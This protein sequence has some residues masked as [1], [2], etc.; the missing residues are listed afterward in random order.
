MPAFCLRKEVV[1]GFKQA[2]RSGELNPFKMADMESADRHAF[3]EKYVGKENAKE[4]NTLFESKLLLKNQKAGYISWAKKVGGITPEIRRDMLA[5]IEKLDRVLN[6]KE[7]EIF[8]KDLAESRLGIDIKPE[9]AKTISD[10]SNKMTELKSKADKEGLFASKSDRAS[11]GATKVAL[12]EY[13]ND[14]KLKSRSTSFRDAP[15][16]KLGEMI[17]DLPGVMKSSLSSLDNSFWGRQGIKTLLDIRTSHIWVKNFVKSFGDISKELVGKDAIAAIKA[18]IYSRPNALNGKY[19]AGKYGLSV[20]SEE[21][22]PSSLPEKIPLLGKLF[23]ASEAAYNGAALRL[24]ADLADRLIKKAEEQGINTLDPKQAE[25]MGRLISSLT[26]RGN[27]GKAESLSKEVNSVFFSVKFLKSNLDTLT[28]HQFDSKATKF[29]KIEAAKNLLSI[30]TTTAS[31]LTIAKMLNPQSVEEDPRSANFGKIKIFGH[32]TDITGGMAGLITLAS[33]LS[34]TW[35]E[36]KLSW[37]TKGANGTYKD[38]HETG[39]GAQNALD[40]FDSFW[41][42]KLSPVAGLLRDVW[43][44]KD[45]SGNPITAQNVL[46]NL[47]TPLP[48]QNFDQFTK[49]P[50]SSSVLGSMILDGLGLSVSSSAQKKDWDVNPTQDLVQFKQAVGENKFSEANDKYNAMYTPWLARTTQSNFYKGLSDAKKTNLIT[51]AKQTIKDQVMKQ[52]GFEYKHPKV[53]KS[54]RIQ[55]KQNKKSLKESILR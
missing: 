55:S 24:R 7:G 53:S 49:D 22:Y 10:L 21:A 1:E 17:K 11:Y 38:L 39:F 34:P 4:V 46:S 14:L 20:L 36:G 32:W 54:D 8:L 52:Y 2:L 31:V 41:Q 13:F 28:A 29:T 5:K 18:D 25:G 3:L 6:P 23:K 9:E 26:G 12:E 37:W 43:K 48:I 42:G 19:D 50:N 27:L 15:L 44:G 51:L 30:A 35:H 16:K 47:F 40:V 33:R 45:Y